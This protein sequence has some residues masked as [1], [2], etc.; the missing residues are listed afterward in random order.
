MEKNVKVPELYDRMFWVT[1]LGMASVFL[2]LD[3]SISLGDRRLH[4]IVIGLVCVIAVLQIISG[5]TRIRDSIGSRIS[6]ILDYALIVS[7]V[8]YLVVIMIRLLKEVL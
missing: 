7:C 2:I 4:Y 8:A 5:I 1:I 3:P 6:L